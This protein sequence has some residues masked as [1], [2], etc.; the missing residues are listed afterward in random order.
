VR[1]RLGVLVVAGVSRWRATHARSRRRGEGGRTTRPQRSTT[2][3]R[4]P[5]DRRAAAAVRP[6]VWLCGRMADD[7]CESAQ[8]DCERGGAVGC[9]VP[10]VGE[11]DDG[12]DSRRRLFLRVHDRE[13]AKERSRTEHRPE[14]AG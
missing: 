10:T 9:A 3:S 4:H 8:K 5:D 12:S 11:A 7:P 6:T 2:A 14:N 13:R 1:V